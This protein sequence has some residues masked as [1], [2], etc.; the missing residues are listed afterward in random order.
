MQACVRDVCMP[1]RADM[2]GGCVCV[3]VCVYVYTCAMCVY[4]HVRL[5]CKILIYADVFV[6]M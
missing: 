2:H 4:I 6:C 1:L 5:R 3:C